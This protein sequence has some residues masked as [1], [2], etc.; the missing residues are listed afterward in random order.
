MKKL[1]IPL[2][3]LLVLALTALTGAAAAQAEVLDFGPVDVPENGMLL[4]V[5]YSPEGQLL[6]VREARLQAGRAVAALSARSCRS[7]DHVRLFVLEKGSYTPL[8]APITLYRQVMADYSFYETTRK[9]MA[10]EPL[11]EDREGHTVR[12]ARNE[13]EGIRLVFASS[14]AD[15]CGSYTLSFTQFVNEEGYALRTEVF[16]EYY[17]SCESNTRS[18]LYPDALVPLTDGG[19]LYLEDRLNHPLYIKV[20]ADREAPAGVYTA[21]LTLTGPLGDTLTVPLTAE[22]W[23]FALPDTPACTTAFGLSRQYA[24]EYHGLEPWTEED[25]AL[26]VRYYEFLLEH[27]ISAYDLPYD[28]TDPRAEAYMSDPRVTSFCLPYFEEWQYGEDADALTRLY[29]ETVSANPEWAAKAYYY[30]VDEPYTAAQYEIY[31]DTVARLK[32]LCPGYHMVMPVGS[33]EFEEDGEIYNAVLMHAQGADIFCPLTPLMEDEMLRED[34]SIYLPDGRLWWYV[35]C[36]PEGDYCN[37][38]INMEGIRHRLL[39]W[40]QMD[41]GVSGLLYWSTNY[42]LEGSP[43]DNGWTYRAS[44]EPSWSFEQ[45]GDGSLLYP[46]SKVGIDGPIASLRLELLSDGIDDFDLLTLAKEAFGQDY[47]DEKLAQVTTSLTDYTHDD[48]LLR[49]VREQIGSDLA[50]AN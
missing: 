32:E 11:A 19:D 22:V 5:A 45:F 42:W 49:L 4:A 33:A 41:F 40:Q 44:E 48:T 14:A 50:A 6:E 2:L 20:W 29:Y 1:L 21:S 25:E 15:D 31:L 30:V 17:I 16:E 37:L 46:G 38:F 47:V 34:I 36:G 43:W 28:I 35:C 7:M 24:A 12:L 26:F 8:Q 3:L 23:D 39:L 18:G 10:E 13:A 9:V 27:N